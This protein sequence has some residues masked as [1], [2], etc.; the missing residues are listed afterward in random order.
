MKKHVLGSGDYSL[1]PLRIS[2]VKP[3]V[4]VQNMT[5]AGINMDTWLSS[6]P[7]FTQAA[8]VRE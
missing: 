7:W 2:S 5:M 8:L 1:L 3:M 4:F 6:L